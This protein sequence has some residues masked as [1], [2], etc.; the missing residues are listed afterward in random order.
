MLK[1]SDIKYKSIALI[2]GKLKSESINS[3]VSDNSTIR[4]SCKIVKL[5]NE[6]LH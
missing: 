5:K 2:E 6:V 4:R 1:I 3:S